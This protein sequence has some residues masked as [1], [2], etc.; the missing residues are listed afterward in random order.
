M[1]GAG[2]SPNG[3]RSSCVQWQ[4]GPV[5]HF[6]H[7]AQSAALLLRWK[8]RNGLSRHRKYVPPANHRGRLR[9]PRDDAV[10]VAEPRVQAACQPAFV[11][12]FIHTVVDGIF[13]REITLLAHLVLGTFICSSSVALDSP[14]CGFWFHSDGAVLFVIDSFD[15]PPHIG[16]NPIITTVD[17][18]GKYLTQANCHGQRAKVT[19]TRRG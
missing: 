11:I 18:V 17:S 9:P 13:S 15:L 10:R 19:E 3:P 1:D 6:A 12:A 5:G 16:K 8:S 2:Q 4:P 7:L 14:L